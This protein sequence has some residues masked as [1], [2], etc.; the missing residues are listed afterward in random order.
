MELQRV[1]AHVSVIYDTR[2]RFFTNFMTVSLALYGFL[3]FLYREP[4]RNTDVT[5][6]ASFMLLMLAG[7]GFGTLFLIT[8]NWLARDFYRQ[9]LRTIQR[10]L[11]EPDGATLNLGVQRYL[12]FSRD[13]TDW[14]FRPTSIYFI[15]NT[16]IALSNGIASAFAIHIAISRLSQSQM[17]A[18]VGILLLLQHAAT[19]AY[20]WAYRHGAYREG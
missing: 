2:D 19:L 4:P 5:I 3:G 15:Y 14:H 12:S 20:L 11:L 8:G 16:A 13:R 10:L 7:L 6:F 1:I 9:R 17:T 18:V